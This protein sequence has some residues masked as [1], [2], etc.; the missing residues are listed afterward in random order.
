MSG[1]RC[2]DCQ[3]KYLT[4][5][6]PEKYQE[7][8][9]QWRDYMA[10]LNSDLPETEKD[11]IALQFSQFLLANYIYLNDDGRALADVLSD[12]II[13][14]YERVMVGA[15][16]TKEIRQ[17]KRH[18]KGARGQR[19]SAA[20][21][22]KSLRELPEDPP[23]FYIAARGL[24]EKH[25][26]HLMDLWTDVVQGN[27]LSGARQFCDAGLAGICIEEFLV[28]F[29]LLQHA[30]ANQGLAHMRVVRE[31]LDYMELFK[32]FP[33]RVEVFIGDDEK[34][35]WEHLTP[36]Q[37]RTTLQKDEIAADFYK[38]YC[39]VGSHPTFRALQE[40]VKRLVKAGEARPSF[41]MTIG[42]TLKSSTHW[43]MTM[44][45]IF[46]TMTELATKIVDSFPQFLNEDDCRHKINEMVE[47]FQMF[48]EEHIFKPISDGG[49]D[50][51]K[52]REA[53]RKT[54]Q[55]MNSIFRE[56]KE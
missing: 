23:E 12:K 36:K 22:I 27:T 40:R 9:S 42:G 47:S 19:L 25:L 5:Y 8:T 4:G 16:D 46:L 31:A 54:F 33:Q 3:A 32:K 34:K 2:P 56:P 15:P 10:R 7:I 44:P 41:R 14:E 1:I 6:T 37:V 26:Q 48:Q 21:Y 30:F 24:F 50:I 45:V 38:L 43:L 18:L 39:E 55:K 28:A 52:I 11:R 49:G 13:A 53:S 20:A 35:K 17:L 51:S 29:H